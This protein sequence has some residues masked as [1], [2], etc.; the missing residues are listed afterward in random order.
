M[1]RNVRAPLF[2]AIACAAAIPVLAV[3]AYANGPVKH[4]DL[5]VLLHLERE[6]GTGHSLANL[7]VNL[8]DLP[9]LLILLGAVC[10]LGLKLG[11]RREVIVAVIVVAGANLT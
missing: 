2:A 4:A 5:H 7:L 11:R 10:W 9:A 1:P 6:S 3:A 8:G